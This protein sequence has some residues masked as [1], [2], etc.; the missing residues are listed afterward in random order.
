[1]TLN[2]KYVGY[3]KFL[4]TCKFCNAYKGVTLKWSSQM[5]KSIA[6][7]MAFDNELRLLYLEF[8][9]II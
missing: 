2:P 3:L 5:G 9:T 4:N 1:M 7:K 8:K 6:I